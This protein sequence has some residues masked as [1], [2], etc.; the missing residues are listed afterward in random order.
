MDQADLRRC[1]S[2]LFLPASKPPAIEKARTLD[3]D[4][5]VLDLEDAVAEED[6]AAAREAAS[7]ATHEGFGGRPV[8]IR[9]NPT[10]SAHY[11]EDVVAVRRSTADF[12]ILAKAESA[13]M[14]A[15]A[16]WLVQ[17]PVLAMIETPRAVIDAAA[18]ASAARRLVEASSGGAQRHE[19]RM[20]EQLHVDQARAIIAKANRLP[21]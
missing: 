11:G 15:D 18:I 6:K 14:V 8:A 17:K 20:I 21:A 7:M 19:G 5:V 2:L 3:A 12:V 10:G 1:R 9:M 4:M 13:K 16:G